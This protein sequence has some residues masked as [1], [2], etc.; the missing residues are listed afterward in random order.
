M[1]EPL[2]PVAYAPLP[3]GAALSR[4][5]FEAT[6]EALREAIQAEGL[7]V[8]QEID[9]RKLLEKGGYAILP[10]RQILFFHPRLVARILG[11]A[12]AALVEAPL[13]VVVMEHPDGAVSLHHPDGREAFRR[14]PGLGALAEEVG[15]ILARVVGAVKA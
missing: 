14:H 7:W 15:L 5:P 4:L 9:P 10:A 13:K 1:T 11:A 6:L 8:I 2:Q 3:L 12:P